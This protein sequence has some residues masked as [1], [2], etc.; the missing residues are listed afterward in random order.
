MLQIAELEF[1]LDDSILTQR[2]L[3]L[4]I[5]ARDVCDFADRAS[6]KLRA[7]VPLQGFRRNRAPLSVV[8]KHYWPRLREQTFAELKRAALQQVFKLLDEKDQPFLPPEVVLDRELPEAV[9]TF[10]EPLAAHPKLAPL[11]LTASAN[12]SQGLHPAKRLKYGEPLQFAVKYL[13]DPGGMA[14]SPEAPNVQAG[15][16]VQLQQPGQ[17]GMPM[18]VPAGPAL[19]SIPGLPGA[20]SLPPISTRY[21]RALSELAEPKSGGNS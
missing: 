20:P 17:T 13:V 5:G 7:K 16:L 9:R 11:P 2:V 10:R 1:A 8:R 3:W 12:G 6:M 21:Q 14:K 18:G 4:R 19:P 15:G